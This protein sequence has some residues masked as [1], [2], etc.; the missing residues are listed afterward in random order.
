M[1]LCKAGAT[2][3]V[4]LELQPENI[5]EGALLA[6]IVLQEREEEGVLL[7]VALES[8]QDCVKHAVGV[9]V[10]T[11][12]GQYQ[13][14]GHIPIPD[15]I[16]ERPRVGKVTRGYRIVLFLQHCLNWL[17]LIPKLTYE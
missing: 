7:E 15:A 2:Y 5:D 11:T 4:A 10:E 9:Q 17:G 8:L 12:W 16:S 13:Q 14:S 3:L 1:R 6:R